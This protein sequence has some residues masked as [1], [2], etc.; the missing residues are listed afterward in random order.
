VLHALDAPM[1]RIVEIVNGS[2]GLTSFQ[3]PW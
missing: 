1:Q 2:S 3:L